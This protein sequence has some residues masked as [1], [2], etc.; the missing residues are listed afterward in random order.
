[1]VDFVR[2][3]RTVALLNRVYEIPP[4]VEKSQS[5]GAIADAVVWADARRL[6]PNAWATGF[7]YTYATTFAKPTFLL[8]SVAQRGVWYYFPLAI[9]FKTPT[10]T[11]IAGAM[12]LLSLRWLART[13]SAPTRMGA[14]QMWTVACIGVPMAVYLESAL[15]SGINIGIR[16]MLPM[17]PLAF[18]VI[19]TALTAL[20]RR[21]G[22]RGYAA[23]ALL[24]VGLAVESLTAYPNF[25]AFFN[26]PSGGSR[27][28]IHLLGDSN[29]DWGQDL[30][31]LARWQQ[32]HRD[33][34]L[35]FGYFGTVNPSFYGIDATMMPGGF[36]AN[37]QLPSPDEDCYIAISA[38]ILQGIYL[39]KEFENLY[40]SFQQREPI[41]VLGGT[42][43]I[44]SSSPVR[45][46]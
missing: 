11:L 17:Y 6:V 9:L 12:A 19:S 7:V 29:L 27:G 24:L 16:H 8:G 34:K 23:V 4:Q 14:V 1:M 43:Y 36:G 31:L 20:I 32:S 18:I 3:S 39:P 15:S 44:Y 33:K 5:P 10:A 22:A 40:R 42:T 41:T 25:I 2:K 13:G 35:Y 45:Q 26:T 30:K 38:T 21:W 46:K 37:P 28:G